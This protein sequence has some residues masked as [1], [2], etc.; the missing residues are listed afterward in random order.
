MGGL[1]LK[2]IRHL[3]LDEVVTDPGDGQWDVYTD[4][5]WVYVPGEG[6]AFYGKSPQCNSNRSIAE[7]VMQH[8]WP[9][10]EL[11]F[12]ERVCLRH[13]CSDYYV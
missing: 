7:K 8:S 13:N 12:M 10:A 4:R 5:W 9:H 11:R 3:P 2:M 6:L 1:N